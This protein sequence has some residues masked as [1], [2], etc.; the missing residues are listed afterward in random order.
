MKLFLTVCDASDRLNRVCITEDSM[1][2]HG[3]VI[4]LRHDVTDSRTYYL[5]TIPRYSATWNT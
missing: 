1:L 3:D 4:A 2:C 5:E